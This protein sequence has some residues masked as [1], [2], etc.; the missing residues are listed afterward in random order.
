MG[1]VE[2]AAGI[3]LPSALKQADIALYGAKGK[4]RNALVPATEAVVGNGG[5]TAP[6]MS[7]ANR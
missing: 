3:D 1:A 4:G 7:V 5:W 2:W 6:N